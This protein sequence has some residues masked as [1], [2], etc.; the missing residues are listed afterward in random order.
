MAPETV[1]T[2]RA[3]GLAPRY[4]RDK[5]LV[6]SGQA[7]AA[8]S[9]SAWAARVWVYNSELVRE[10]SRGTSSKLSTLPLHKGDRAR[11]GVSNRRYAVSPGLA[12]GV[13][14]GVACSGAAMGGGKGHRSAMGM[15]GTWYGG[16]CLWALAAWVQA[17]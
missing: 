13:V 4:A 10:G 8:A 16:T 17:R 9:T 3:F 12:R 14:G 15:P 1:V 5:D 11:Y 2:A 6:S 7:C